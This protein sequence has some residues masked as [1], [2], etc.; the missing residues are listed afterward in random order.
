M[1]RDEKKKFLHYHNCTVILNDT[2][3]DSQVV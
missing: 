1:E 3:E 2:E